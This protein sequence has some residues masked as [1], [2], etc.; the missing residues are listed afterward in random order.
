MRMLANLVSTRPG[1]MAFTRMLRP[2]SSIAS[3]WVME[4]TAALVMP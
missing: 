4:M 1:A 2:P 3:V